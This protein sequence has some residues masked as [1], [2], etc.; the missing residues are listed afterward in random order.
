MSVCGSGILM[1]LGSHPQRT[2]R[3]YVNQI[4]SPRQPQNSNDI[5]FYIADVQ[6]CF[7]SHNEHHEHL[8]FSYSPPPPP[9]GVTQ[10]QTGRGE[11]KRRTCK[12]IH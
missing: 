1:N 12:G 3:G 5:S 6:T 11:Y 10:S 4:L 2:R 8:L 9:E 7:H